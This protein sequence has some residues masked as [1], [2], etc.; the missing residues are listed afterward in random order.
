MV[1]DIFWNAAF[2]VLAAVIVFLFVITVRRTLKKGC[3]CSSGLCS[4]CYKSC[5]SKEKHETLEKK[6][7]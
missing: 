5:E 6:D 3:N 1:S 7:N 4:N 2:I